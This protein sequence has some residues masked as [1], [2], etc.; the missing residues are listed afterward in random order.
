MR[1]HPLLFWTGILGCIWWC[2]AAFINGNVGAHYH[3]MTALGDRFSAFRAGA[4]FIPI[5]VALAM[6]ILWFWR[7]PLAPTVYLLGTVPLAAAVATTFLPRIDSGYEQVYWIGN[8]RHSI[9]WMF[10]PYNGDPQRGGDYFLV[11][12]WGEELVPYYESSGQRPRDHF[13]LGKSNAFD[14]GQGGSLPDDNC[15]A[16]EYIFRCEWQRG[17]YVYSM[18]ISASSVPTNP[19]SLFQPIE[20]LLNGF[21]V[22]EQ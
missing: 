22:S 14:N 9:P 17:D 6:T 21:E 19:K 15:L 7:R 3:P 4:I 5:V 16:D 18:S 2:S 11:R 10:G 1:L 13:I 12:A 8:Q 20:E